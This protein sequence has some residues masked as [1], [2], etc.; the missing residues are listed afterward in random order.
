MSEETVIQHCSPT[1]AGIKTGSLFTCAYDSRQSMEAEVAKWNH[2]FADKGIQVVVLKYARRALVYIYRASSLSKDISAP[3]ARQ[4]LL[5]FDYDPENMHQCILQLKNRFSMDGAFPHEVGLFLGYPPED[6]EGFIRFGG[7]HCKYVGT[8]K[9]YGN[10]E[11]ACQCFE[12]FKRCT[13]C[14]WKRY[15]QGCS[16]DALVIAQL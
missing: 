4:I 3:K 11:A 5:S 15:A 12:Q 7:K 2:R 1:L 8:W 13:A 9:V 6:V 10:I 14:Y 16:F